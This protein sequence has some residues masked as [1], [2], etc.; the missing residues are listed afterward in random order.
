M[1]DY[2]KWRE[3]FGG[4]VSTGKSMGTKSVRMLKNSQNPNEVVTINEIADVASAMKM[5]QSNEMREIVQRAGV[6]GEPTMYLLEE[7]ENV[8]F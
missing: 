1:K 2:A 8:T 6:V 4:A 5:G 7:V 3:V